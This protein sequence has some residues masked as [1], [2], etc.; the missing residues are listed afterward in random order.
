MKDIRGQEVSGPKS[1]KTLFEVQE[2]MSIF[3]TP[4]YG[5]KINKEMF[6][7]ILYRM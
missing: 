7:S 6:S 5:K 3:R 2:N 4:K 1:K